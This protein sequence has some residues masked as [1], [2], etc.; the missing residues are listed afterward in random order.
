MSRLL[1]WLT[2]VFTYRKK[3]FAAWQYTGQ[4]IR[5]FQFTIKYSRIMIWAP[6]ACLGLALLL[7]PLWVPPVQKLVKPP[8]NYAGPLAQAFSPSVL[9]WE[10]EIRRWAGGYGLDSN[11]VATVI[12]IESC[13]NPRAISPAGAIGLFQVMPD[14]F[15]LHED[16]LDPEENARRGLEYLATALLRS[17]GDIDRALAGYNGGWGVIP[18]ASD[19]WPAETQRYVYWGSGI[20]EEAMK[21]GSNHSRLKEW[22]NA[23]GKRLCQ[24]EGTSDA[25]GGGLP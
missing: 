6:V 13:G 15:S 16:P 3:W 24:W 22:M 14:H 11:L 8:Q 19:Q 10:T 12:Q 18:L 5:I 1:R 21:E 9:R 23:G 2:D 7:A 4:R 20:Y 17:E 25:T